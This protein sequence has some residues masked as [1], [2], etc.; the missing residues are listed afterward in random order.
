MANIKHPKTKDTVA[1]N[2][3]LSRKT[4]KGLMHL[5]SALNAK[6]QQEVI[7]KLVAWAVNIQKKA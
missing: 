3:Q 1:I 2:L 4:H 7:D 6:S 5:K